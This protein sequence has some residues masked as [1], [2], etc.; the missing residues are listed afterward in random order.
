MT[1]STDAKILIPNNNT[2]N[3][4]IGIPHNAPVS[5]S[6][7][8]SDFPDMDL[9]RNEMAVMISIRIVGAK[10]ALIILDSFM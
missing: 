4:A 10:L 6:D 9:I 2:R 7:L 1:L 3:N 5:I 8:K